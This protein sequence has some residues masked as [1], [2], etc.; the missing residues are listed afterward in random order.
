MGTYAA[1]MSFLV[2]CARR[3][4]EALKKRLK[5]GKITKQIGKKPLI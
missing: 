5:G 4:L 3:I 1:E 2:R